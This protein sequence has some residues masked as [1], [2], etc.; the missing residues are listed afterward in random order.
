MPSSSHS[1]S[2]TTVVELSGFREQ[3]VARNGR[4]SSRKFAEHSKQGQAHAC[5]A[6]MLSMRRHLSYQASVEID[7]LDWILGE[8][9]KAYNDDLVRQIRS[10][11][12][13][14]F[15]KLRVH[16]YRRLF[17]IRHRSVEGL[18]SS[19]LRV[20]FHA[21]QIDLP[22][23]NRNFEPSNAKPV[24]LTWGVGRTTTEAEVERLRRRRQK[25][26]R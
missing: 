7:K 25:H 13:K 6:D 16:R 24:T 12:N 1:S 4:T 5:H 10:L 8:Y 18:I 21:H 19:L 14:E 15:G 23:V 22:P 20:Q 9:G 2:S 3:S 26:R 11:L 17:V